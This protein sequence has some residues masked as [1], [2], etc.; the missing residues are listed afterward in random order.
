MSEYEGKLYTQTELN[1]VLETTRKEERKRILG[2]IKMHT[3]ST[4]ADKQIDGWIKIHL[5]YHKDYWQ[6]LKG[7]EP[8]VDT[9]IV[10]WDSTS[11]VI[12]EG[13]YQSWFKEDVK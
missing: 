5:S 12:M 6:A 13:C 7:D 4:T 9:G 8:V 2:D 3:T 11:H 1:R 10:G